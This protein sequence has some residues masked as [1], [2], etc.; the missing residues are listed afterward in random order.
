MRAADGATTR[1]L[2]FSSCSSRCCSRNRRTASRTGVLLTFSLRANPTSEISPP[3]GSVLSTI[4]C[5]IEAFTTWAKLSGRLLSRDNLSMAPPPQLGLHAERCV[6][7][8]VY[9]P[10]WQ[11]V[12]GAPRKGKLTREVRR[13]QVRRS[14]GVAGPDL[15]G[16]VEMLVGEAD[17]FV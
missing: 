3:G 1:R 7:D 9:T 16:E 5:L 4:A 6:H 14:A 17:G 11:E 13:L 2:R 15:S 8:T 12:R 10:L